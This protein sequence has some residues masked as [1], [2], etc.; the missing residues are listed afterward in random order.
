MS[1][2]RLAAKSRHLGKVTMPHFCLLHP[3]ICLT[4]EQ[5]GMEKISF[6]VVKKSQMGMIQYVDLAIFWHIAMTSFVDPGL[7]WDALGNL[8]QH[9]VSVAICQA[10]NLRSSQHQLAFKWNL[11]VRDLMWLQKNGTPKS[12][13]IACYQFTKMHYLQCKDTLIE[14]SA[15]SWYGSSGRPPNGASIVHHW[16][17]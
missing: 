4:T 5:N 1:K 17:D 8:S 10:A 16:T 2:V 12:L 14:A 6:T 15:V 11:L 7:P 13:W 9:L 3:G